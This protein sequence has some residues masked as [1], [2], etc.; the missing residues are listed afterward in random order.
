MKV[1][2]ELA[3]LNDD[4]ALQ[5][6]D[7]VQGKESLTLKKPL[8]IRG[9]KHLTLDLNFEELGG[10]EMESIQI[11]LTAKGVQIN[12]PIELNKIYLLHI[13]AAAAGIHYDD[14]KRA[15]IRDLTKLTMLAQGF[16]MT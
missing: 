7:E 11:Q 6:G 4:L 9:N 13:C 2:K 15:G 10:E 8:M 14:L 1:K 12:G 5:P 3:A 16:L